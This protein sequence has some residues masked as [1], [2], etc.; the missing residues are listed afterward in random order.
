MNKRTIIIFSIFI[1]VAMVGGVF[2]YLYRDF[3]ERLINKYN[4]KMVSCNDILEEDQC[5]LRDYCIGVFKPSC[6]TCSD[7]SFSHCER[8]SF[9]Q[10]SETEKEKKLCEAT[11]GRWHRNKLGNFCICP[12]NEKFIK[13]AGCVK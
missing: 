4:S 12:I 3:T 13:T 11:S 5:F 7:L 8:L 2:I 10:V 6:S 9:G 1:S